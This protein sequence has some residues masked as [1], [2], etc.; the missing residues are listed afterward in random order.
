[1]EETAHTA[2]IGA[3][4]TGLCVAHALNTP[5]KASA[6]TS[7]RASIPSGTE[8]ITPCHI[9]ESGPQVGGA[10]QSTQ[11]DGYLAEHGPNSILI[12]DKRVEQLLRQ[13][14]LGLH[15]G[16]DEALPARD[17]AKKRY[18]VQDGQAHAMP[19]SPLGMLRTP[20]FSFGGKLRFALEP[21]IGRYKGREQGLGEESFADF[22]K[23]RLG[24][25][26]LASA[27]G[28]FVSG[29]YAGN[30]ENLSVRH[31]FPRLWNLEHNYRSFILG[32]LALQFGGGN[33][34]HRLAPAQMLSFR[35]GMHA[36]PK[37]IADNLPGESVK[38]GCTLQLI[39]QTEAGWRIHWTDATGE[40]HKGRYQK[41][42]LTTPHHRLNSLPLPNSVL[43]SLGPVTSIESPPVTSLV[44]GF[45]RTDVA[46][47]LDGF[48][49]LIKQTENSPLLGVL[50]SSSM[51]SGRAPK[52]H[53]TLTCMMGGSIHPEYAENDDKTVLDELKR[54]L[55][56]TGT[57]TFRHQTSWPHAI[58]QYDL[59]YQTAL[60]AMETCE[61]SHPGLHLAGNY[62]GGISVGDCI[63]NGLELGHSIAK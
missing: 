62:R 19:G 4:I 3:G 42:V 31:A 26:M 61:Q 20:L 58:P 13:V 48:G 45:K 18:I 55:G 6:R 53:V 57:P 5:S 34:P 60:D 29:I 27:A 40:S 21:F 44:L 52:D 7:T 16:L 9:L 32:A 49:M 46:H 17:E 59:S 11:E 24:P 15:Q 2:I 25:D 22:V 56:V 63:V 54:L 33:N 10:I 12:K 38:L 37:A 8:S 1:M 30:P 23:R 14:G 41:L 51:F 47:P 39:E 50:F 28:P 36:M 43:N 35:S